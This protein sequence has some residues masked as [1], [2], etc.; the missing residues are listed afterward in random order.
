MRVS[1]SLSRVSFRPE[2]GQVLA[3][4]YATNFPLKHAQKDMRLALALGD[5]NAV[6]MPTAAAANET[7]KQARAM[8]HDDDDFSAVFDA[9]KKP[10]L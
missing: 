7:M 3:G 2:R 5:V 9:I 1:L 6:A 8:G 4:D 10:R